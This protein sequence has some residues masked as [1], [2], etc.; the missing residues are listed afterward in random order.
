[1][2]DVTVRAPTGELYTGDADRVSEFQR[3]IPGAQVLSAEEAAAQ[4][5]AATIRAEEGGLTGTAKQFISSA[6]E[7]GT[8]L[9]VAQGIERLA[10]RVTGGEA[11]EAEAIERIKIREQENPIAAFTGQAAGFGG[12]A[13][14]SGGLSAEAGLAARVAG[15]ATKLSGLTMRA[16]AAAA[17]FAEAKIAQEG[18]KRSIVGAATRGATEGALLGAG[19][20]AKQAALGEDITVDLV[21]NHVIGGALIGGFGGALFEGLGAAAVK[22][23]E[24]AGAGTVGA[25]IGAGI[26][27]AVGGLPGAAVGGYVGQRIGSLLG[28]GA[29]AAERAAISEVAER[30]AA[31]ARQAAGKA[32]SGPLT[33]DEITQT[34]D[35]AEQEAA[36]EAMPRPAE[37]LDAAEAELQRQRMGELETQRRDNYEFAESQRE[38]VDREAARFRSTDTE[39]AAAA[40]RTYSEA[41]STV[42]DVAGSFG[43][44]RN[45][46]L[47]RGSR[48]YEAAYAAITGAEKNRTMR[49]LADALDPA[50][51]ASFA[52]IA[53]TG[54]RER[55]TEIADEIEQQTANVPGTARAFGTQTAAFRTAADRIGALTEDTAASVAE[56]H[57]IADLAKREFDRVIAKG[58]SRAASL[59]E[60]G[61]FTYFRTSNG[62]NNV[63]RALQDPQ[64]FGEQIAAT[65]TVLNNAWREAIEPLRNVQKSLLR[66]G[67]EHTEIDPFRLESVVDPAKALPF[68]RNIGQP[69]SAYNVEV[70][71]RWIDSQINLQ[72]VAQRLF[73]PSARQSARIADSLAAL[74]EMR[75][76]LGRAR[77]AS[78]NMEAARVV[79]EDSMS[80]LQRGIAENLGGVGRV[81]TTMLDLERRA[82][83]E[84]TLGALV[85]NADKR[86][87]DAATAFVRGAERPGKFVA[88]VAKAAARSAAK[89]DQPAPQIP[90]K[91][92]IAKELATTAPKETRAKV[93]EEAL[94]QI[95]I[96]T[97][98]AGTPQAMEAFAYQGTRP[99]QFATDPRLATT[100]ANASARA[101]AF[102]YAKRPP[103]FQS[104]TLQPS[105]VNRQLSDG[106]LASW[107]AY[108]ATAAQP[109]SVL[110][111]LNKNT[112][113]REQV[114]T[115]RALYPAIYSSI[116]AKIMD[117]LHDSRAEISYPQ[118]VLLFQMFGAAT[119]PSLT[120]AAI[121]TIQQ[122]F[123]PA[124]APRQR[125]GNVR[126]SFAEGLGAEPSRSARGIQ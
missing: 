29:A 119:D 34:L 91:E 53:R 65:Q 52:R 10:G 86:I 26:G 95:A 15:G 94:R 74:Q 28:K 1:M 14:L 16:G 69:E 12:A 63:R 82:T 101:M 81:L 97:A 113:R 23:A 22:A 89:A 88:D 121:A 93:A 116:Q 37:G 90:A 103:T 125:P 35:R 21:A 50:E 7:G 19:Q 8:M 77:Q 5:R 105:L 46:L 32:P 43:E 84:R 110:D 71:S 59:D 2:A 44:F 4:Q 102:L 115:L 60:K 48:G 73:E 70:L 18:L 112:V 92:A 64:L 123:A 100:V 107:R 120:P 61:V 106:Q 87:S 118:R 57:L 56:M 25:G 126:G 51:A 99:M 104:D 108:T 54:L 13:L 47:A 40:R 111:D 114:E 58:P 117:A 31:A 67:L 20:V 6:I 39:I 85:G 80:L 98:V 38:L 11:G 76:G 9:P 17:E 109:L 72:Q 68:M 36:A 124:Q 33:A 96:V 62:A 79:S 42:D 27:G 3:L 41:K 122:S 24:S 66:E 30:E 83:M 49:R 55:L 45:G 75:T 78:A